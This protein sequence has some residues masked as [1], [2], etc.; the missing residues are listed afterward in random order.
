MFPCQT[1]YNRMLDLDW[2]YAPGPSAFCG[3]DALFRRS[4]LMEVGGFDESLIAG[5][6]PEMCRRM[7]AAG[8]SILHVN[9]PMT[10]HDLAMKNFGQYWTRAM[11][12]GHAY[13]EVSARFAESGDAFWIAEARRNRLQVLAMS[14]LMV[15][16]VVTS[17]WVRSAWP[18]AAMIAMLV[19]VV[20]R[21]AWKARWKSANAWTLLLY[22]VHSHLQQVPIFLGQ[23]R[24]AWNTRR[25]RQLGIVE[26]KQG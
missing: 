1:V 19:L 21:T 7:I 8:Y 4:A 3:G 9:L 13:G 2:M 16:G 25:G 15:M 18:A 14:A 22:A 6:E 12:A 26:Y 11:R 24:Y 17:L 20:L 5:E 23:M 10:L